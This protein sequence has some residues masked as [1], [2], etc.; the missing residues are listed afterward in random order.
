MGKMGINRLK[1][2]A[3]HSILGGER[4]I[5]PIKVHIPFTNNQ[6]RHIPITRFGNTARIWDKAG[7]QT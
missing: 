2:V 6:S 3:R 1:S 4:D 5:Y 7:A